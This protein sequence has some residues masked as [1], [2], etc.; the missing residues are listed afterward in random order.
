MLYPIRLK[1]PDSYR[2]DTAVWAQDMRQ[3][4]E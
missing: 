4:V 2:L 3:N 1:R